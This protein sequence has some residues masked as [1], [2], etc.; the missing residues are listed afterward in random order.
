MNISDLEDKKNSSKFFEIGL[1][2]EVRC[3]EKNPSGF[4]DIRLLI[5]T[6]GQEELFRVLRVV[7]VSG[8]CVGAAAG[9]RINTI[10]S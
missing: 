6:G 10:L 3:G 4:F 1:L 7:P 8:C 9:A 2:S 5:R